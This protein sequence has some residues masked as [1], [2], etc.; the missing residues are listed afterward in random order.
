M[1]SPSLLAA[2]LTSTGAREVAVYLPRGPG[3]L[4]PTPDGEVYAPGR[5]RR[6][7]SAPGASAA[8]RVRPSDHRDHRRRGDYSRLREERS[9][10]LPGK[11]DG[12][13]SAVLYEDDGISLGGPPTKVTVAME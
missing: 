10:A 2:P 13:S 4:A 7:R 5:T 11:G 6:P 3:V 1:F 9:R 12:R 8:A